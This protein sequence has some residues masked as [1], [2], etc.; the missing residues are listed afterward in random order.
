MPSHYGIKDDGAD[1]GVPRPRSQA[2]LFSGDMGLGRRLDRRNRGWC[3]GGRSA[4]MVE[5]RNAPRGDGEHT[6][7]LAASQ[8]A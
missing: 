5:D 8:H 2:E 6:A 7:Q 3:G 1:I 4:G